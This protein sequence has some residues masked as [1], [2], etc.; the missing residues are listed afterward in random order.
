M[1]VVELTQLKEL[2]VEHLMDLVHFTHDSIALLPGHVL[3]YLSESTMR[4]YITPLLWV[5][6]QLADDQFIG[7]FAVLEDT[8]E[9]L[10]KADVLMTGA[11]GHPSVEIC[12]PKWHFTIFRQDWQEPDV[13]R[14]CVKDALEASTI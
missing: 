2:L 6:H 7:F 3:E 11:M 13:V 9:L 10:F 5:E 1:Q 8:V 14:H 12:S 4:E